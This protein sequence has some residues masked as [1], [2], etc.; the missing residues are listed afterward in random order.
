MGEAKR[1]K[2]LDPNYGKS[3]MMGWRTESEWKKRLRVP[4]RHWDKIKPDLR[5]VDSRDDIDESV[6]AV[7]IYRDDEGEVI[8]PT[9][10]HACLA[11]AIA[12]EMLN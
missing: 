5:I 10:A 3:P 11:A 8:K 4:E 12:K 7:W 6:S 2:K 9:G 1:R